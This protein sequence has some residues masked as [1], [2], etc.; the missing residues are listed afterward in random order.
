M[1]PGTGV[2]MLASTSLAASQSAS[3]CASQSQSFCFHGRVP[4]SQYIHVR[5]HVRGKNIYTGNI[6]R[7][8]L[9]NSYGEFA[10]NTG[11]DWDAR[12]RI[13]NL[14]PVIGL[15]RPSPPSVNTARLGREAF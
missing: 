14:V 7:N 5:A 2:R 10:R 15:R 9:R 4:A 11:T 12:T 6:G 13:R 8:V 3:Q 1:T